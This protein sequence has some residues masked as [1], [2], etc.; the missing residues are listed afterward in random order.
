MAGIGMK[1]ENLRPNN[2]S[3]GAHITNICAALGGEGM[4]YPVGGPRSL[5]HALAGVIEQCGGRVAT[6]APVKELLFE[7]TKPGAATTTGE[8][9]GEAE[10]PRCIGVQLAD[11]QEIKIGTPAE[12]GETSAV[13]NM[14][15]FIDTFVRLLP[16]DIRPIPFF[17]PS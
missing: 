13:I 11:G 10:T 16:E 6:S 5:C 2:T 4:F 8:S 14:K 12:E 15:G 17:S 9:A 3:M 1:G 7:E